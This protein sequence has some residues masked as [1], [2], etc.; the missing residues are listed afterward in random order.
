MSEPRTPGSTIS[1]SARRYALI[2]IACWSV[3]VAG[4][5]IGNVAQV[6][7]ATR[8]MAMDKAREDFEKDQAFRRW[9]AM[10]GG[11]TAHYM[12]R[13]VS[14]TGEK[15]PWSETASATIGA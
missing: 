11:V 9:S 8:S 6:R 14:T 7:S 3:L 12:L 15:G 2:S 1:N 10:H 4:L 5:L 13:W